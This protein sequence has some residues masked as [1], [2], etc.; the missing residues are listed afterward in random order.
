MKITIDSDSVD[1]ERNATDSF[2]VYYQ[3]VA[4]WLLI[5]NRCISAFKI[6]GR[7]IKNEVEGEN[8][9]TQAEDVEVESVPLK[10]ALQAAIALQC[11]TVRKLE[12]DCLNLVTDCLLAEPKQIVDSWKLLCVELNQVLGFIPTLAPVLTDEQVTGLTDQKFANLSTIMKDINEAM[13]KPDVVTVSDIL[14]LRLLPWMVSLR[15]FFQA[16][17]PV[18][19]SLESPV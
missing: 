8:L 7:M 14:E 13:N 3:R 9:Y 16:Q 15:E 12:N 4:S 5:R 2:K 17:I 19:D 1:I 6:N 11:N 18:I 10:V